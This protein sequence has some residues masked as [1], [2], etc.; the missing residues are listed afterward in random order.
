MAG[1]VKLFDSLLT[2]SLWCHEHY[3]LR[4][5]IAMLARC[6]SQ[7]VVEGSVPGFASLCRVT[8]EEMR[9]ALDLLISPDPDSR[10][11]DHEG[12]RLEVV[13]GGWR[14]LNYKAYRDKGQEKEGSKAPFMRALRARVTHG[15]AL[16]EAV[17]SDPAANAVKEVPPTGVSSAPS[18]PPAPRPS[19][20]DPLAPLREEILVH[21]RA[22]AVPAGLPDVLKGTV[23]KLR[24]AMNAR[25]E[26]SEWLPVFR[27]AVIF[28]ARHPA[29]AWMRGEG[30]RH[31]K[32]SLDWLLKPG[33]AENIASK[34]RAA[35]ACPGGRPGGI[36]ADVT[37]QAQI[38]RLNIPKLARVGAP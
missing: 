2:S 7:G 14:I 9:T 33:N 17:T 4:I 6:N 3:V 21:W 24:S 13:P 29:A 38:H 35:P 8:T 16:P 25:L 23:L 30:E 1:Y 32:V 11:T 22:V 18:A 27:E 26:D 19:K 36:A 5:W 12:R 10:T 31:W 28:A 37:A 15:N 20:A 34:A